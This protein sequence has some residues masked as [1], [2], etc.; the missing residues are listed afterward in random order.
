VTAYVLQQLQM[1]ESAETD[2]VFLGRIEFGEVDQDGEQRTTTT[3]VIR[4]VVHIFPICKLQTPQFRLEQVTREY[5]F[6]IALEVFIFENEHRHSNQQTKNLETRKNG[7][8][9]MQIEQGYLH[10]DYK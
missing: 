1:M 10:V 6:S 4:T 2:D 3:T 5:M 8:S 9:R 7:D